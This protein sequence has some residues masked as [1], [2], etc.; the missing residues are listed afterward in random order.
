MWCLKKTPYTNADSIDKT[1]LDD[2]GEGVS[3]FKAFG[4][5]AEASKQVDKRLKKLRAASG[6]NSNAGLG[7]DFLAMGAKN[8]APPSWELAPKHRT[9]DIWRMYC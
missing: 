9:F 3:R 2:F 4:T 8:L 1:G 5:D 6:G 7:S